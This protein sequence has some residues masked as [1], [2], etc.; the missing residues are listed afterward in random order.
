MLFDGSPH[1]KAFEAH[2][3]PECASCHGT[4]GIKRPTDE[5][6]GSGPRSLCVDCH[7]QY[8]K[9]EC[10]ET[11]QHFRKTIA[12]LESDR[13]ALESDVD[14]LG[15]R[16]FDLDELRFLSTSAEEGVEK[17]RQA[18]H[19]FD[20]SDFSRTAEEARKETG[21]LRAGVEKRWGEYRYRR[22]GLL[23]STALISLFGALLFVKIRQVDRRAGRQE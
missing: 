14:A 7:K 11:A 23:L 17:T 20:R 4:H 8:G 21:S 18:I 16:G 3:W 5:Q 1:K 12:S 15:E 13:R 9:P 2:R 10:I 22:K 6:L 19:T